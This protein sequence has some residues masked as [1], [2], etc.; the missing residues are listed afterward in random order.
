MRTSAYVAPRVVAVSRLGSSG[1]ASPVRVAAVADALPRH[2]EVWRRRSEDGWPVTYRPTTR[3]T[4]AATAGAGG[5][6]GRT[7]HTAGAHP[8]P[9]M[10]RPSSDPREDDGHPDAEGDDED[11]P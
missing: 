1:R 8:A 9:G 4:T 11:K 10:D 2:V 3:M 5:T 7:D 6:G